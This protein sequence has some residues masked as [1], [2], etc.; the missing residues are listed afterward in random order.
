[1]SPFAWEREKGKKKRKHASH[2]KGR[3]R[4][5]ADPEKQKEIEV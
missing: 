5:V 4:V 3:V 2:L 1:M